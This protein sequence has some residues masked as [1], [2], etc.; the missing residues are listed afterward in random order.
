MVGAET[1]LKWVE[2]CRGGENM[3]AA[4]VM[5]LLRNSAVREVAEYFGIERVWVFVFFF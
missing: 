3:E 4:H 5:P 2:E 1:R